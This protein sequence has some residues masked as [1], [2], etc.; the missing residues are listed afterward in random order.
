MDMRVRTMTRLKLLLCDGAAD[1]DE[2]EEAGGERSSVADRLTSLLPIAVLAVATV[3]GAEVVI[4]SFEPDIVGVVQDADGSAE[5]E[6]ATGRLKMLAARQR[7][8]FL[9]I[10]HGHVDRAVVDLREIIKS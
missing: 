6:A 7:I 3:D 10:E 5:G 9:R 4:G 8:P 2:N 1:Q